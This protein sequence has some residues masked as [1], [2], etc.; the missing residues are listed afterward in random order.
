MSSDIGMLDLSSNLT[1]QAAL[2]ADKL[3]SSL[4]LGAIEEAFQSITQ[5]L[6]SYAQDSLTPIQLEEIYGIQESTGIY[7]LLDYWSSG[8]LVNKPSI[9]ILDDQLLNGAKGAYAADNN[10]IYIAK[11]LANRDNLTGLTQVLIEEYGHALDVYFN[12]LQDTLGDEGEWFS[13]AVSGTSLSDQDKLRLRDEDDSAFLGLDNRLIAVEQSTTTL[14]FN[15]DSRPDI[16]WRNTTTGLNDLWLMGGTHNTQISSG[17]SLTSQLDINWSIKGIS[18]F[19]GDSHPDILWRHKTTGQNVLWFMGGTNNTQISSSASLTTVDNGW[20][21][22]GISDFNGDGRPDILWRHGTAGQNVLW[23]MGG[24]NNIQISGSAS[25]I[26]VDKGWDIKGI[27]DFNS[28]GR[29]DLLWRH[30]TAGQNVLWF[31]GGTNNTQ[32]SGSASLTTVDNGWDIK[33]IS[34]F[35]SDNRPDILWRHGTAGQNVLWFMGSTNNTQISS[36]ASLATVDRLWTPILPSWQPQIKPDLAITSQ[37]S[38]T[39]INAGDSVTVSAYT[40]NQGASTAGSSYVRYWLSDDPSLNISSDRYLGNNY[41]G[42]LTTSSSEY[43][44]LTF[45]YDTSWGTGTKYILFESDGYGYIAESNESNNV[46]YQAITVNGKPDLVITSQYAPTSVN[47]GDSITVSAYTKNQGTGTAGYSYMRYLL[48]NDTL[49]SSDDYFLGSDYVD[50]LAAGNSEY[51]DLTFIYDVSWGTGTKY[52]LFQADGY[53]QI[54]EINESN[55]TA[56]RAITVN[57]LAQP[58]LA[59][60]SQYAPTSANVGDSITVSA[61]TKNQGTATAGYSYL[62]YYL[63]NDITLSSDDYDLGYDSV[64][65][66][67]VGSSEYDS[68][69][70]TYSSSWGTG[71]KYILFQ[72]DGYSNVSESNEGNNVAYA[73]IAITSLDWYS[74]NLLDASLI[75]LTRSLA[76]DGN[77]S[78]N[79]MIAIFRDT[80]DSGLIDSNEL[81]GLRKILSSST[82]FTMSDDVKVLSNK[83]ANSDPANARSGIGNLYSGS[84]DIQMESLVGKWFLGTDRPDLTNPSSYTY[85][86]TSGSLFQNGIAYT[87]IN[88]GSVGD[89][90]FLAGLANTALRSSTTIQNMFIDNGDDTYTVRFYNGGVA[91]Y[92]TIDKYLPT[93]SWNS[94]I[95]AH[96]S[97]SDWGYYNDSTNEL[98][99][100]LAEKA[101]AQMN[102]SGWLQGAASGIY[103][104]SYSA[105]TAGYGG[106]AIEDITGLET[107][108]DGLTTGDFT[109][110]VNAYSLG[111]MVYFGSKDVPVNSNIVG[112]HGYILV[113]YNVSTQVFVLYNPWGEYASQPGHVYLSINDLAANYNG[114]YRTL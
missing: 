64:A 112:G 68:L 111:K 89:C 14:D 48:S 94:F 24:T 83:I 77:L 98:W 99:V 3:Y 93:T 36:S 76:S 97:R 73:T 88:Q 101:Y 19:N 54:T 32:I 75:T 103:A 43:D 12:G 106:G 1:N 86:L 85:R 52:I 65:S 70:F 30:G 28:D 105:I 100:M 81:T 21:I 107:T 5:R 96:Q 15:G 47:T 62:R 74:T 7:I 60:I 39:S 66:L 22:K 53:G 78:R 8:F 82:P 50:S 6:Q 108:Y 23:F 33:G 34:D 45:T 40:T 38:P 72:A 31:M 42:S 35:N 84:S 109:A 55:N 27:S 113:D 87:D 18:D 26:T 2:V 16:L 67:S 95:Y 58:D 10:H 63:S 44:A 20:D 102:E 92:V 4:S 25:L 9:Q 114:W 91:D 79:D 11:S 69:T 17:S 51:D 49:V 110:I 71:T 59:I 37:F 104:N 41:V 13:L 29:P 57:P 56:Y 90:Y 80:K 61:Y 46:A